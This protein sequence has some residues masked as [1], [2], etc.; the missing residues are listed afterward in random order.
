MSPD[1]LRN[2]LAAAFGRLRGGETDDARPATT[3]ASVIRPERFNAPAEAP[4]APVVPRP[5]VKPKISFARASAVALI[6]VPTL[7]G[8]LF[9]GLV[10][11]DQYS[12]NFQLAVRS[13]DRPIAEQ[14]APAMAGLNT[15]PVSSDS[16]ILVE[17]LRSRQLVEDIAKTI[18]LRGMFS[19]SDNDIISRLSGAASIEELVY[20]W[21]KK[22]DV[23]FENQSGIVTA[24]IRAFRAEDSLAISQAA[25]KLSE[26]L[27]NQLSRKAREEAVS[28]AEDDVRRMEIR[29][30]TSIAMLKK[31]RDRTGVID[32]QKGAGA[33]LQVQGKL[34]EELVRLRTQLSI[35]SKN[36]NQNAPPIVNLKQ[37]I[38]ATEEQVNNARAE[39]GRNAAESQ[40]P[41]LTSQLLSEY[42]SLDLERQF[43]EK[44][45]TAT[46]TSLERARSEAIRTQRYLSVFVEP[47]MPQEAS[48][49]RRLLMILTVFAFAFIGWAVFLLVYLT[50]KEH[51]T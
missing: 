49:P 50:V 42:E 12:S 27:V 46:L 5:A 29:L 47:H 37:R 48:H 45:Y 18:D 4:S 36:M 8:A 30:A 23:R 34:Q 21:R 32:P 24:S 14:M 33:G 16:Y 38:A 10:A 20:Y 44:A 31:F 17:Y 35:L 15:S 9:F 3:G 19:R 41:E 2:G 25:L 13:N 1:S 7:L 6:G 43:A 11:S 22:I 40:T 26:T 28:S 39:V 51:I